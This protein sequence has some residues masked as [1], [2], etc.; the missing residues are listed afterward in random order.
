MVYYFPTFL[1]MRGGGCSTL[2]PQPN[3]KKIIILIFSYILPR[4]GIQIH[5]AQRDDMPESGYFYTNYWISYFQ[6]ADS[7]LFGQVR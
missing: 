5:S 1:Y 6:F 4:K 7:M 2:S 3:I